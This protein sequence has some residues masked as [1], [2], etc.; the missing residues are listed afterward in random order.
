MVK[1]SEK[2]RQFME[3][4]EKNISSKLN[5]VLKKQEAIEAEMTGIKERV[6][7]LEEGGGGG[8]N[9]ELKLLK[10]RL[11]QMEIEARA[12][13]LLIYGIAEEKN[14][15]REDLGEQIY[16]LLS[17][18]YGI[19]N[20]VFEVISRAGDKV[21]AKGERARA[22]KIRFQSRIQRNRILFRRPPDSSIFV[23]ADLPPEVAK[24]RSTF[25]ELYN[26][27][28]KQKLPCK[29]TDLFVEVDKKKYDFE[30]AKSFLKS[31]QVGKKPTGSSQ[32]PNPINR[33][34]SQRSHPPPLSSQPEGME[35]EVGDL[36]G[37]LSS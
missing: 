5:E 16:E 18:K 25:G 22:V 23:R 36:I 31:Q 7:K 30:M 4:S 10:Q 6:E 1:E 15:T 27:A 3:K 29:R 35:Q 9:P 28:K 20:P 12:C 14:E 32:I 34:S 21:P 26:W 11:Q 8:Q 13:N 24:M 37:D 33:L 2:N 17:D 19:V